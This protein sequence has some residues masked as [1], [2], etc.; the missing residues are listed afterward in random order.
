[1]SLQIGEAQCVAPRPLVDSGEA[2]ELKHIV[3]GNCSVRQQGEEPVA[4]SQHY[5][6]RWN[7]ATAGG[8]NDSC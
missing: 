4:C 8:S 7:S 2:L 1:M 5:K 6:P 3:K